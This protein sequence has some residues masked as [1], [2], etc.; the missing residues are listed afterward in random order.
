MIHA[1]GCLYVDD[2]PLVVEPLR[3]D[4]F[5]RV[6]GVASVRLAILFNDLRSVHGRLHICGR[7]TGLVS[8]PCHHQCA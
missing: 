4:I 1:V 2:R 5:F 7:L 3:D 6:G 8:L